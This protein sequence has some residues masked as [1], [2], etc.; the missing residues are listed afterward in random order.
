MLLPEKTAIVYG[1]GG[2]IGGAVARRFAEEGAR[3]FLAGRT[4]ESLER[5]AE[6]IRASGGVPEL[7]EVDALDAEAV[8]RHADAVAKHAGRIDI[9]FNLIS[10]GDVQGTPMAEMDVEDYLRP[11]VTAVRTN[12]LTARAA[13]RHMTRQG[14]GVI[15]FF[16]GEGDP[17]RGWSLGGLQTAF[18]AMEAMR[19]QLAVELGE[20]G[21]RT[22]T[23]R[24][25]GV[26]ETVPEG[27]ERRDAIVESLDKST[28]TGRSATLDDVA[29]IAAFVAS[30]KA[31]TMTAATVNTSAGALID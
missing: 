31:R 3:V 26:P 8:D 15:L 6:Q 17:P 18:H 20:H 10:H 7:A 12:F 28:L 14:A 11:V 19:R 13:A 16:G 30:D 24:T 1:G 5:V 21:V 27:Y 23:L 29:D 2:S 25:G 22:V 9:S 4:I